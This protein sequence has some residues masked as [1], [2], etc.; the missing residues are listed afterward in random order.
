MSVRPVPLASR[1][2]TVPDVTPVGIR[3]R[4]SSF[5]A[6]FTSRS[7]QP[8][9]LRQ[10]HVINELVQVV[11][12]SACLSPEQASQAVGGMLRFFAARLPSPLF[13]EIQLRLGLPKIDAAAAPVERPPGL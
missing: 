5:N 3:G 1:D 6:P 7:P 11:S 8:P 12:R 13:G 2:H 9:V 10:D 4:L